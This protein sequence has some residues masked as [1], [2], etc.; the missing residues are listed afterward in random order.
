MKANPSV[1]LCIFL[2]AVSGSALAADRSTADDIR[3]EVQTLR[4]DLHKVRQAADTPQ[5]RYQPF[6]DSTGGSSRA[7]AQL[8]LTAEASTVAGAG[9]SHPWSDQWSAD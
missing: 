6:P 2:V 3:S 9:A 4:A 7:K 1:A 8:P 5:G